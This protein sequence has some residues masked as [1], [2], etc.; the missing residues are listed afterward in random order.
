MDIERI[1]EQWSKEPPLHVAALHF[2]G[3]KRE[4]AKV[5][6]MEVVRGKKAEALNKASADQLMQFVRSVPRG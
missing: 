4:S 6:K 3:Y 5:V 2:M 1:Y